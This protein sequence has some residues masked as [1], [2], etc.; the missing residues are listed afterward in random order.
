MSLDHIMICFEE[1]F[2][3]KHYLK[4]V[5]YCNFKEWP[6]DKLWQNPWYPPATCGHVAIKYYLWCQKS[7]LTGAEGSGVRLSDAPTIWLW[8]L[9][10]STDAQLPTLLCHDMSKWCKEALWLFL[11]S[12]LPL[13]SIFSPMYE[14]QSPLEKDEKLKWEIRLYTFFKPRTCDS[15]CTITSDGN[16]YFLFIYIFHMIY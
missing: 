5:T 10:V 11:W 7:R 8:V 2:L 9:Q 3:A 16:I 13:C 14:V 6:C 12:L 4:K 1:Y 15:G